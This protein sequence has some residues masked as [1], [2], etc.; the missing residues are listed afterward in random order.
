MENLTFSSAGVNPGTH[1]DQLVSLL[2]CQLLDTHQHP[3]WLTR[4]KR[5]PFN[6]TLKDHISLSPHTHSYYE[7]NKSHKYETLHRIRPILCA[8]WQMD[9]ALP[10]HSEACLT[11]LRSASWDRERPHA[12]RR[13]WAA[14]LAEPDS[15]HMKGR[16]AVSIVPHP[17]GQACRW[18]TNF[19]LCH[20]SWKS[21]QTGGRP[22][23]FHVYLGAMAGY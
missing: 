23:F 22:S 17:R 11:L 21:R 8:L 15:T 16:L 18:E 5:A 20:W 4:Q 19:V 1:P 9:S 14:H 7:E 10:C 12:P 13:L 2:R 6:T 3:V